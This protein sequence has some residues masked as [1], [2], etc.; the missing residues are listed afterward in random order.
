[1]VESLGATLA[2]TTVNVLTALAVL[3]V[4]WLEVSQVLAGGHKVGQ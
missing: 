1:M 2:S 3:I 4:G